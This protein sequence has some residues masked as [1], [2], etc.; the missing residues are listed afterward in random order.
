MGDAFWNADSGRATLAEAWNE[1]AAEVRAL[2]RKLM[3][4]RTE[5][6]NEAFS[7]AWTRIAAHLPES[8]VLDTRS[9]VVALTYRVCMDLYRERVRRPEETI[10]SGGHAAVSALTT[11]RTPEHEYL[12]KELGCVLSRALSAM[13]ERLAL[14]FTAYIESG[15]YPGVA[16]ALG[17]TESNARK[18]IQEARAILRGALAEY[19]A[20]RAPGKR[21]N[22]RCP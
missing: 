17:I 10:A 3:R 21:R 18:R 9:W 2:C 11:Q 8:K 20:G 22:E 14:T 7:R 19:R 4:G 5:D 12:L 15:G 6:A 13:P 1:H 16:R